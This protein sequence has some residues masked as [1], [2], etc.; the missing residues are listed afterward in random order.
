MGWSELTNGELLR[1]AEDNG[2]AVMVS[3]DKNLSYQ[4]NLAGRKLALIILN[5]NRWA[6]VSRS[7]ASI[8]DAV[9]AAAPG[10]FQFVVLDKTDQLEST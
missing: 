4:Q 1:S 9:N 5:T 3:G 10:S 8:V 7:A 2:F 6:V